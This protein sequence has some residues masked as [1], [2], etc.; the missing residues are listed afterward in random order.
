MLKKVSTELTTNRMQAQLP[1]IWALVLSIQSTIFSFTFEKHLNFGHCL[2]IDGRRSLSTFSNVKW[3]SSH[4]TASLYYTDWFVQWWKFEISIKFSG[5]LRTRLRNCCVN[6][7]KK[8][9]YRKQAIWEFFKFVNIWFIG[10][11]RYVKIFGVFC[12]SLCTM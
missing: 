2:N 1:R 10:Q 6:M 12:A 4:F 5:S 11:V 3:P 7:Y 9:I 8:H